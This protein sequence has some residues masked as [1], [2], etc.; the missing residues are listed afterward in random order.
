M[1]CIRVEYYI[2]HTFLT[3][4]STIHSSNFSNKELNIIDE[5][6]LDIHFNFIKHLLNTQ[7]SMITRTAYLNCCIRPSDARY[8]VNVALFR[9]RVRVYE[10]LYKLYLVRS[11]VSGPAK[12]HIA[13]SQYITHIQR[14]YRA[15]PIRTY[16]YTKMHGL[17]Y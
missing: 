13:V 2:Y 8:V 1:R 6:K 7:E 10:N 12:L 9:S 4:I 3:F 14:G 17:L 11:L 5:I 15:Q 16:I